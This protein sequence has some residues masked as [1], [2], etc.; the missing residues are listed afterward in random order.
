MNKRDRK[1]YDPRNPLLG[2]FK[3]KDKS[4]FGQGIIYTRVNRSARTVLGGAFDV[5]F[6]NICIPYHICQQ[7]AT[8]YKVY[9]EN[10]DN[11]IGVIHIKDAMIYYRNNDNTDNIFR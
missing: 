11:I 7:L 1:H 2:R 5:P 10:I 3:G 8:N 6:R 4:I 9:E